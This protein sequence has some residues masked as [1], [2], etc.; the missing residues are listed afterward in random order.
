ML[1]MCVCVWCICVVVCVCVFVCFGEGEQC[2]NVPVY[3][4]VFVSV[5]FVF[6]ATT[7]KT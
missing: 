2:Q 6:A 4:S 1:R 3:C 7:V 5:C